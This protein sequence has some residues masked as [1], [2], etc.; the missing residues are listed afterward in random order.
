M[1]ITNILQS[2]LLAFAGHGLATFGRAFTQVFQREATL[3][4]LCPVPK[5]SEA[6]QLGRNCW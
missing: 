3:G 5:S 2:L 6:K 4:K 1:L